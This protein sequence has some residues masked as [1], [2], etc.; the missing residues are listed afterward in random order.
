MCDYTLSE[1]PHIRWVSQDLILK[2]CI[3][4][5]TMTQINNPHWRHIIC[6]QTFCTLLSINTFTKNGDMRRRIKRFS[7]RCVYIP[8]QTIVKL[9]ERF[10]RRIEGEERVVR[11]GARQYWSSR[12]VVSF[13]TRQTLVILQCGHPGLAC[14]RVSNLRPAYYLTFFLFVLWT[15]LF[16]S[17]QGS[18]FYIL[19]MLIMP[20]TY[21]GI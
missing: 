13:S 2:K 11:Q 10:L 8:G 17:P 5:V 12:E 18:S 14:V 20:C 3:T 4:I 15:F 9:F 16:R 21:S 19:P 6:K 1:C 7:Q